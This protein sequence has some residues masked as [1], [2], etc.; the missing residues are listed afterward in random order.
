M[1]E[2]EQWAKTLIRQLVNETKHMKTFTRQAHGTK[3]SDA[4]NKFSTESVEYEVQTFGAAILAQYISIPE[5]MFEKV[6]SF[7]NIF[8][9]KDLQSP[10]YTKR[11]I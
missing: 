10:T 5:G 7:I 8:R 2:R 11:E 6:H 9:V 4:V 3:G 1:G